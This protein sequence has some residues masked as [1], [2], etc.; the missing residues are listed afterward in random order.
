MLGDDAQVFSKPELEIFADDV[1][2]SHGSTTGKLD[3]EAIFYLRSRG[4]GADSA[5][6]LLLKA[7]AAEVLEHIS[8][9]KLRESIS[10]S[11]SGWDEKSGR[12]EKG[13]K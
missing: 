2:C 9:V 8:S 1:K 11:L 7:F 5:R 12:L 13:S 10:N 6:E 3:E 4:I